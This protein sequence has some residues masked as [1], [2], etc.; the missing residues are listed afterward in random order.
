V[1]TLY[2]GVGGGDETASSGQSPSP[3]SARSSPNAQSNVAAAS[4]PSALLWKLAVSPAPG[5]EIICIQ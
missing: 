5:R 4:A 3:G 1:S 2:E